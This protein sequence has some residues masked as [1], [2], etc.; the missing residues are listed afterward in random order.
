MKT[1]TA[2][3]YGKIKYV[4]A[5]VKGSGFVIRETM[6]Y[7]P[8]PEWRNFRLRERE[9]KVSEDIEKEVESARVELSSK[10]GRKE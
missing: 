6:G 3:A 2:T 10:T 1:K 7:I 9:S 8:Y 5:D 4:V